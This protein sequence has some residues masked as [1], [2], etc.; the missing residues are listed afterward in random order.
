[1]ACFTDEQLKA[2]WRYA[3]AAYPEYMGDFEQLINKVSA[4]TQAAGARGLTPDE[5]A[6]AFAT[7]KTVRDLSAKAYRYQSDSQRISRE[8]KAY[9]DGI[10]EPGFSKALRTLA[11]LPTFGKVLFHSGAL[12]VTHGWRF[13]FQ[14]HQWGTW[15]RGYGNSLRSMSRAGAEDLSRS[16]MRD[17]AFNDWIRPVQY[18]DMFGRTRST[19]GL[20]A[21]PRKIYDD[22]QL[23][24]HKLAGPLGRMTENSFLG[25]KKFRLDVANKRWNALP[26][27]LK[28]PEMRALI[29]MSVNHGTGAV[30]EI[31]IPELL[32]VGMFSPSLEATRWQSMV[33]DPARTIGAFAPGASEAQRYIAVRRLGVAI[34]MAIT[35]KAMQALAQAISGTQ[36]NYLDPRKPGFMSLLFGHRTVNFSGGMEGAL[37]FAAGNI[38]SRGGNKYP[39]PGQPQPTEAQR[40]ARGKLSPLAAD[41][42]DITTG[43]TYL[44]RQLP[45]PFGKPSESGPERKEQPYSWP[46]YAAEQ[47]GPLATEE[48]IKEAVK[49]AKEKGIT[50]ADAHDI[51]DIA[52]SLLIQSAGAHTYVTKPK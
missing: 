5:V 44:G 14:P 8:A 43:S 40:Y 46:E 35:L 37:R 42:L 33:L 29:Q 20:A 22:V 34:E 21:D 10:G 3:R 52:L 6:K 27:N 25:L 15:L 9:V 12:M 13:L 47:F 1:M 50:G 30:P 39:K 2:L 11:Y 17:P 51:A 32:K 26:E 48:A 19:G 23:Y 49:I 38:A 16:I 18:R 28:T 4:D 41:V 24:A 45:Y 31:Q 7:P 36:Q